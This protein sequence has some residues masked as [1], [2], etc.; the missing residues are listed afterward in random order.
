[1]KRNAPLI[2]GIA[3]ILIGLVGIGA[4]EVVTSRR[5]KSGG[6]CPFCGQAVPG[7]RDGG[8]GL[9]SGPNLRGRQGFGSGMMGPGGNMM[10]DFSRQT[11][12]S[13]GERIYLTGQSKSGNVSANFGMMTVGCVNCHKPDGSGGLA[14]PDGTNSADIRPKTLAKE[15]FSESDLKRAITEGVDEKGDPLGDY[16]P[17]W[18]MSRQDLSDVIAYLKT[19]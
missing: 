13:N 8:G 5:G 11:Y 3:L 16:M 4:A 2:W 15:G 18:T 14:F 10:R 6:W 17:R 7:T 1:M 19:L 12:A 9:G